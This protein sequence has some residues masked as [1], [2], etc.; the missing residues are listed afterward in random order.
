MSAPS[1]TLRMGLTVCFAV[2]D[3]LEPWSVNTRMRPQVT[4]VT[5]APTR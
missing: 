3:V 4:L 5:I 2:L 1:T